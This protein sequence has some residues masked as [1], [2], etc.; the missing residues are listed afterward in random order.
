[1]KK[2]VTVATMF[3]VC[4]L[5]CP[6]KFF[7]PS[8]LDN[9]YKKI[10]KHSVC[11]PSKPF[12]QMVVLPYFRN[13][14]QIVHDCDVYKKYE[15]ALALM[16]FYDKWN[17]KFGDPD[18]KVKRSLENLMITWGLEKKT[19]KRAYSISG[20]KV[21]N[22]VIVGLTQGKSVIW[23]WRG[24]EYKI[25]NS[26]FV[27]E[28]VHVSL[29]ALQGHGD[30]DHEGTIKEGWTPEHTQLISDINRAIEAFGL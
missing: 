30:Y 4:M 5:S 29:I 18:L 9:N 7:G 23:V 16:I 14:T 6:A 1:M 17:L 25:S 28:L 27:H 19:L 8:F 20:K 26:S 22:A 15:T 13:A 11:S 24:K 12:P 3:V 2:A 10:Y 21:E